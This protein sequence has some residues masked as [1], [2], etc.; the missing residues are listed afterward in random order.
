MTTTT[1][2]TAT[3]RAAVR[4][5]LLLVPA[6]L[7]VAAACEDTDTPLEPLITETKAPVP[8]AQEGA[9]PLA[10][11]T[12]W[13]AGYLHAGSPTSASYAPLPYL[14]YNASGGTMNITRPAGTTGRY[15][16]TFRG[17]SALL[18]TRS[19]VHVT[20]YGLN[21][22]YCKPTNGRLVNDKLEVRC[23]KASTRAPANTAFTVLVSGVQDKRAFAYAHR[24]TSTDYSPAAAGSYNPAGAIR[25]YRD[26][27]GRYRIAFNNLGA[28]IPANISG[29]VQVN[30]VGTGAA[31]CKL[32]DWGHSTTP[33]LYL[34]V[35][36]YTPAGVLTDSKFTAL[37]VLPATHLAYA[38]AS[39]PS[40]P[41][42][43]AP[44]ASSS[45]P[46]GGA[47][48]ITRNGVGDY[49]VDWAGVDAEIVDGGTVQVTSQGGGNSQCK[50][51][52]LYQTGATVQCFAPNGTR[53]DALYTVMLSS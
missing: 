47:V 41:S 10:G 35:W 6:A 13:A 38:Y 16:V 8:V 30:A 42:Y 22:T 25:V 18:G 24:P 36:C 7:L 21:D 2:E 32:E 31:H 49:I 5:R 27:V 29:H 52:G 9:A 45:N 14:S 20:E 51:T 39:Q 15:V 26:G 34:D 44:V 4:F 11:A 46:A 28:Q 19:T 17:L 37:F 12:R 23:F 40:S 3:M 1:W 48:T 33:N 43:T 50:A 53:V